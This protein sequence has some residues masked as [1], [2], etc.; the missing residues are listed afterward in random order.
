MK[1]VPSC[2]RPLEESIG[3]GLMGFIEQSRTTSGYDR[4]VKEIQG[5]VNWNE[6]QRTNSKSELL[7]L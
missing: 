1:K 2:V 3:Y 7:F 4:R 6:V 5:R